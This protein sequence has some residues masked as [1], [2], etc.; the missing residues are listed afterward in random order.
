[1]KDIVKL[2]LILLLV[3]ALAGAALS[4][5]NNI[6]KP[7]IEEQK[8]LATALALSTALPAAANGLIE[9]DTTATSIHYYRGYRDSLKQQ[10]VGYAF[11]TKENGYSSEIE[12]MVG[13]DTTG[14]IVGIKILRQLETP[15]LGTKIEE[16]S[17]GQ[18]TPYFQNQFI[19]KVVTQ[20]AVDKDGGEIV[21]ITGATISSRAVTNS[22]KKGIQQLEQ[23]I[24][25]F[26]Q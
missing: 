10:L 15:G 6:T 1:M 22:I 5:V 18:T 14:K 24:G 7:R 25:G 19:N 23:V 21:S 11:L 16:I 4:L 26:K 9:P 13:V 8:R 17:H 2:A 12:T 3:T 20:L